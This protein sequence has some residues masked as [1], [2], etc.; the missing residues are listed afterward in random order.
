MDQIIITG[1]SEYDRQSAA[2]RVG[3][4]HASSIRDNLRSYH[5]QL[6]PQDVGG[7]GGVSTVD[8]VSHFCISDA[9]TGLL[10][11]GQN[12]CFESAGDS[13]G[14]QWAPPAAPP[15]DTSFISA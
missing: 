5:R 2:D 15:V 11:L 14:G 13:G 10:G 4:T 6:M 9:I 12:V 8:E 7:F 3:E 1:S